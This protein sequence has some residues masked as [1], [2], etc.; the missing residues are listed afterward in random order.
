MSLDNGQG[1]V[2]L[3]NIA[4]LTPVCEK[5]TAVKHCNGRDIWVITHAW[6]SDAYYA[7]LLS[8]NGIN[9]VP[10]ISHSG[11]FLSGNIS[12]SGGYLKASPNGRK[13]AAAHQFSGAE[14]SDFDN[15]TGIVS[16]SFPM[17]LPNL[18]MLQLL[19]Q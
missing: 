4:L 17:I 16:H 8:I 18:Q 11:I 13:L 1:D 14:L 2:E 10:V 19:G 9:P 6:N 12:Y 7:Y 5:V 15:T 3:K